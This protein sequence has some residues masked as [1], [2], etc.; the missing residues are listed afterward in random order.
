M[1]K[2]GFL[3]YFLFFMVWSLGCS[4]AALAAEETTTAYSQHKLFE[5]ETDEDSGAESLE[6]V[7]GSYDRGYSSTDQT[8]ES[9]HHS[10]TRPG[11]QPL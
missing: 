3:T 7:S 4:L 11:S 8:Y 5:L 6:R 1:N 10:Q 2:K 9:S